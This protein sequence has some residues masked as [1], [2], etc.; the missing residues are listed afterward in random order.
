MGQRASYAVVDGEAVDLYYSHWGA[1]SIP[2]HLLA[3]PDGMLAYIRSLVT[4][5]K[6]LDDAWAE[7]AILL[8][9]DQQRLLF[10]GGENISIAPHLRRALLPI[11][12][13]LWPGWSIGWA[14]YG[15]VDIARGLGMDPTTVLASTRGRRDPL[16]L[17]Q[18]RE[19]HPDYQSAAV[20]IRYSD[21]RV[22]D[23]LFSYGDPTSVGPALLDLCGTLPPLTLPREDT[24][25]NAV[26]GPAYIDEGAYIDIAGRAIW[27]WSAGTVDPRHG[28]DTA[29]YWPG[30]RVLAHSDGL[31][32][33]VALS[34]R[35]PRMVMMPDVEVMQQLIE[36]LATSRGF[37]P[38]G[39]LRRALDDAPPGEGITAVVDPHFLDVDPEDLAPDER[40]RLLVEV[41][42]RV[43][44]LPM[45]GA[46]SPE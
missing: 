12:R 37:D 5:D 33:Q 27:L 14:T 41:A 6:L 40:R 30:W 46:S 23:H 9:R 34:G 17:D 24:G 20:T 38:A 1:P 22:T 10:W 25:F 7:G 4:T 28:E 3:G 42:K 15:I 43:L 39:L 31:A 16:T 45:P 44:P 11:L 2:D 8:D 19:E 26:E 29:R 13:L 35:D 21:D 32:R 18:L 36:D